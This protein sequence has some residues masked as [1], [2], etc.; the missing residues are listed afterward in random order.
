MFH[1]RH[2]KSNCINHRQYADQKI[3]GNLAT[4]STTTKLI[5]IV[6]MLTLVSKAVIIIGPWEVQLFFPEF[7]HR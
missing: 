7:N 4:T 1:S 3:T 5:T 2:T 6:K